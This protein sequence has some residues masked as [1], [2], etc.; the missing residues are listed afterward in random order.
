MATN[1][2]SLLS[3]FSRMKD[4]CEERFE[5]KTEF[6][7]ALMEIVGFLEA[8]V[9]EEKPCG[10]EGDCADCFGSVCYAERFSK[11]VSA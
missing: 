8:R 7:F 5:E 10:A 6:E 2:K 1:T 9:E 3:T 11:E 4:I